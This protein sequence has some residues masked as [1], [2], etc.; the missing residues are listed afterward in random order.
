[1]GTP[2]SRFKGKSG[3]VAK[4]AAPASSQQDRPHF[5]FRYADRATKEAWVFKPGEDHAPALVQFICEMAQLSWGE[6]EAQKA[7]QHKRHHSQ[8]ISS[9]Q[10]AA[11]ADITK[12]KLSERFNETMFRFRLTGEQRLWGFRRGR[13]FHI[14]WWD[15][16]HKVYPTEKA[17]T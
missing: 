5:C 11:Q 17:R 7:G 16:D 12:R 1:V 13:V 15:P 10:S 6:I 4:A 3:R 8:D 9:L 2:K 14:V